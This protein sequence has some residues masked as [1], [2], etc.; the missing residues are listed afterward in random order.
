MIP[1]R[2]RRFWQIRQ[3]YGVLVVVCF[4]VIAAGCGPD[5]VSQ[6]INQ[7]KDADFQRGGQRG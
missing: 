2:V 1:S 6:L 7:L 4:C 3:P 5:R